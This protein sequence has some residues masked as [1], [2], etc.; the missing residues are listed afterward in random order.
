M[1]EALQQSEIFKQFSGDQLNDLADTAI[2]RDYPANYN[3]L[4]K[5]KVKSVKYIIVL[6]G[7]VELFLD[8]TSIGILSRGMSFGDQYVLNQKQPFKHTIKSLEVC[9]IALIT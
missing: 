1:T 6:E 9:K 4:H 8:D 2:V 3:I 7:K 5:D